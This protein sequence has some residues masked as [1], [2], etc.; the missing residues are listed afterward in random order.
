MVSAVSVHGCIEGFCQIGQGEEIGIYGTFS[1]PGFISYSATVTI[2][3]TT[4]KP[5]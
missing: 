3:L 4:Q 2:R 5:F 1:P